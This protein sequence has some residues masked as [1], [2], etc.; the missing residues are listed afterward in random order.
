MQVSLHTYS[1]AADAYHRFVEKG[2]VVH[3]PQRVCGC[4]NVCKDHP[5]LTPRGVLIHAH[6]IKDGAKLPKQSIQTPLEFCDEML[7]E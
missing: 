3:R 2:E 6:E 5:S 4:G 7:I 1:T